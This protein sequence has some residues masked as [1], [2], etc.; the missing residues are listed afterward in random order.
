M[1]LH[2]HTVWHQRQGKFPHQLHRLR[3]A[4]QLE[5]KLAD[6]KRLS[7]Q[8]ALHAHLFAVIGDRLLRRGEREMQFA[9]PLLPGRKR[10]TVNGEPG[11]G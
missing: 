5:V 9:L 6:G 11:I 10:Q 3:I 8:L 7:A 2:R 4:G 1:A